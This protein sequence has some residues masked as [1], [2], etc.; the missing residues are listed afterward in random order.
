MGAAHSAFAEGECASGDGKLSQKGKA[1]AFKVCSRTE[2][3]QPS[4]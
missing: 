4:V 2:T 1:G 3:L